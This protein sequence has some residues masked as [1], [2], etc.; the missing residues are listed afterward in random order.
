MILIW[1]KYPIL[2]LILKETLN[3]NTL[4]N[5]NIKQKENKSILCDWWLLV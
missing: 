5:K 2:L 3:L 1:H 4:V